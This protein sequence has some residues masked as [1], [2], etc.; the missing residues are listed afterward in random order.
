V[1]AIPPFGPL[2]VRKFLFMSNNTSNTS[3]GIGL[4]GLL[5]VAFVVLKLCN[6]IHWSWW[7]VLSPL[8]ISFLLVI[9]ILLIVG[10]VLLAKS[11]K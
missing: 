1:S 7:W 4:P 2:K 6:V 3:G 5:T 11:C 8:W 10:I 9:L